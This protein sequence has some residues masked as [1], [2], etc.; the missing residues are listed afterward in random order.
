MIEK[1]IVGSVVLFVLN[2]ILIVM[3]FDISQKLDAI[4]KRLDK[5]S[6]S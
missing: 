4:L 6:D 3:F 1:L 2:I 5:R